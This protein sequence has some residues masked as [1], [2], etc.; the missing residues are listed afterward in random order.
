MSPLLSLSSSMGCSGHSMP[1]R[2][3]IKNLN[4]IH[5]KVKGSKMYLFYSWFCQGP[6]ILTAELNCPLNQIPVDLTSRNLWC[7]KH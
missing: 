2:T 1:K 7:P 3:W 6:A 4:G 5:Q